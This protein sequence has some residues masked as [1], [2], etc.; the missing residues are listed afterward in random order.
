MTN[1]SQ[2]E[3]YFKKILKETENDSIDKVRSE[4]LTKLD[5]VKNYYSRN[6]TKE[7]MLNLIYILEEYFK[8]RS[9]N[10]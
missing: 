3:I 1:I 2:E 4:L 7:N 8:I 9:M 6:G 10:K 5:N